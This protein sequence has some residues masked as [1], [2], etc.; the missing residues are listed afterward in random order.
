M[1]AKE[2]RNRMVKNQ[3]LFR[4]IRSKKVLN[5]MRSVPRHKF[6]SNYSLENCYSDFPLPIGEN[7]TISQPYIVAYMIEKLAI[8]ENDICLE[9]GSG[10]GYASSIMGKIGKKV[11]GLE[12]KKSL[13]EKSKKIIKELNYNNV[14]FFNKDG[15]NGFEEYA[16]F[17]KIMISAATN[18]VP[19][20]L[21]NQLAI[22]GILIAPL[23]DNFIQYLTLY[24]KIDNKKF[25]INK[26]IGVR[27]VPLL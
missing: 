20:K 15:N 21:L 14:N 2:L 10:C 8:K 18:K 6:I 25:K 5:A 1:K 24:T 12:L 22:N 17:D 7:Q 9:I 23:G 16:P 13:Y 4:G 11:Y 19:S 26:L 3:I 27:F